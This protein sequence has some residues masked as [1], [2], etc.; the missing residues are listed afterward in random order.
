MGTRH[1]S[2]VAVRQGALHLRDLPAQTPQAQLGVQDKSIPCKTH[3]ANSTGK[4]YSL[5]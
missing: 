3:T 2:S 4:Y 1:D 5:E